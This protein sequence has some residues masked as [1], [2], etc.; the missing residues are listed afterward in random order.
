MT[1]FLINPEA[2][3]ALTF[4]DLGDVGV[5]PPGYRVAASTGNIIPQSMHSSS[6]SA[7]KVYVVDGK[8][9]DATPVAPAAAVGLAAATPAVAK[10]GGNQRPSAGHAFRSLGP[11]GRSSAPP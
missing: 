2:L 8:E 10:S 9:I 11:P 3:P 4:V 7:H 6:Q 1:L 5:V